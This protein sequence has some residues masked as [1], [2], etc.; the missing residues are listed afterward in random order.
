[1][2]STK[3]GLVIGVLVLGCGGEPPAQCPP[4][5]PWLRDGNST[6]GE[7]FTGGGRPPPSL[8]CKGRS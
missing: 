4:A 5:T 2:N 3:L 7:S 6:G 1:M 8:G